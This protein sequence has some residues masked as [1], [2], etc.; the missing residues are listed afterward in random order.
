M[1]RKTL[2]LCVLFFICFSVAVFPQS[3]EKID[4]TL[5]NV[6]LKEFFSTIEKKLG[7]FIHV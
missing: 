7:V 1:Q 2:S 4:L 3:K 6:T 5:N